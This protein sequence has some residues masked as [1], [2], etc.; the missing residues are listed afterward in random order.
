MTG[1]QDMQDTAILVTRAGMGHAPEAL[2]LKLFATYLKL[3][4]ANN[5]T[6]GAI[7]FYSD[8]VKLAVEGSPVLESL[9]EL[10]KRGCHLVLCQTCLNFFGLTEKVTVGTIGG[11]GDI[12]AAQVTAAKVIAL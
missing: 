8:G 6:P 1:G 10:E 12:L 9:S 5:T 3:L 2:Q 4:L 7:C 11:M